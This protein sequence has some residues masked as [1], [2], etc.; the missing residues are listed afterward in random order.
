MV[1][2]GTETDRGANAPCVRFGE[3]VNKAHA[4]GAL[5]RKGHKGGVGRQSYSR[6]QDL[7]EGELGSICEEMRQ[8]NSSVLVG[9]ILTTRPCPQRSAEDIE[10]P[11]RFASLNVTDI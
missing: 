1:S 10:A 2:S 6:S 7:R 11:P 8:S 3:L 4:G 5:W 9:D